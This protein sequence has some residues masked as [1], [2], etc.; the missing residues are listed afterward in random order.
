MHRAIYRAY[1]A[2]VVRDWMADGDTAPKLQLLSD[3]KDHI[4]WAAKRRRGAR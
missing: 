1:L 2:R 3:A 4:R